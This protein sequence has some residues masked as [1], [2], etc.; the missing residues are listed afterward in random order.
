MNEL[1]IYFYKK[2]VSCLLQ[3]VLV[4]S[5]FSLTAHAQVVPVFAINNGQLSLLIKQE[6]VGWYVD[7]TNTDTIDR[8]DQK[9]FS[10]FPVN[11]FLMVKAN[12]T[13]F[14]QFSIKNN[15]GRDKEYVLQLP[16]MGNVSVRVTGDNGTVQNLKTGSLLKLQDRSIASNINAVKV[17]LAKNSTNHFFIKL[18]PVYSLYIPKNF[19]LHLEEHTEFTKTDTKR[20]FWQGI[21][22]GIIM[23]MAL[24]NFII[25]IAVK[26]ISYFYYVLSIVSIGVYFIFYYGF[27]IEYLWP[28]QPMWDTYCYT[29]IVPFT[30][31]TRLLFTRTYLH[32]TQHMPTVNRILNMLLVAC[33]II[34]ILGFA[35]FIYHIDLLK[36]FLELIGV[37]GTLVLVLML[38]A[39]IIAYTQIRYK[40]AFYF[41]A[42]NLIL[43][44]GAIAF[45]LREMNFLQDNFLTRY[46]VQIGVLVQVVVF[47]LGLA[48]RYNQTKMALVQ[49]TLLKDRLLLETEREKKEFIKKQKEELQL[50]IAR[51]T[52]DLKKQNI[53]LEESREK[54][55]QLN[56]VK[57][58]LFSIISHDLRNPLA[59][60][61]SYL[62]LFSNHQDKLTE[63]EKQRLMK[64]AKESADN[65][66]HLLNNLL[67]WSRSQMD[68]LTFTPEK[69]FIKAAIEKNIRL[70]QPYANLKN[71]R[72]QSVFKDNKVVIADK[73]M[74]DFILRNFL[75]N[76]IKFSY[77]NSLIEI[78]VEAYLNE[79]SVKVIDNGTG[80]S[81]EAIQKIMHTSG[82]IS[83]PGTAKEK[84]TGLGLII[85]K[86]FI[87]RNNGRL[88]VKSEPGM[89]AVFS[90]TLKVP[91]EIFISQ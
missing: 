30:A 88:I 46:V 21:F 82:I 76:A 40:P 7:K 17:F 63:E 69:I 70:L 84:G 85:C 14:T 56:K 91:E 23:V 9:M 49:E 6:S 41:I 78:D 54:L 29:L 15:T 24:Y 87:E 66:N 5:L 74:L 22:L 55:L 47:A 90:F 3:F 61:Q 50:Q 81:E 39:G 33:S 28:D 26:D 16:K 31:I 1:S 2:G 65:M 4:C 27:G 20:L 67:H 73:D 59:T 10:P 36:P 68:L 25:F 11:D 18:A 71:I 79:I 52:A 35:I 42:A 48:S 57:D 43:I 32:T 75:S 60:M 86:E 8:M 83:R 37:L 38:V 13:F 64:E 44:V 12:W 77:K 34:F 19:T 62:K 80:L 45:I 89:G 51:Q 72:I 53:N 58:K